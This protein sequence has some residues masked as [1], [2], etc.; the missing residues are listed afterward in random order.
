MTTTLSL[1]DDI[2]LAIT[3]CMTAGND[4][5]SCFPTNTTE[6]AQG[7]LMTFVWNSRLPELAQSG[8]VDVHLFR[9]GNDGAGVFTWTNITNPT[10]G[11]PG[12]VSLVMLNG[13]FNA[14]WTGANISTPFFFTIAPSGTVPKEQAVF[15][16]IQTG[17]ASSS[18]PT[19]S[20][21]GSGALATSSPGA[22]T[23][24]SSSHSSAGAIAGGVVGGIAALVLI[25]VGAWLI[26]RRR[27][28]RRAASAPPQGMNM[29]HLRMRSV[30]TETSSVHSDDTKV[31]PSIYGD[32]Q[33]NL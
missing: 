19:T 9:D 14:T 10:N 16:A 28:A 26:R 24:A 23:L 7:Q 22:D 1:A 27:R 18:P 29:G 5:E 12:V 3:Q 20:S 30:A 6:I 4:V 31:A 2:Q 25:G 32:D 33:K 21:I 17:P 8:K 11:F 13:F 15:Q